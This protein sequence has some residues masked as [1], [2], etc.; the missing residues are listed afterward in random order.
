MK[1]NY[2]PV[3]SCSGS[4]NKEWF[5]YKD[6]QPVIFVA[7]PDEATKNPPSSAPNGT[8]YCEPD[9]KIINTEKTWRELV[10][11]Q[12]HPDLV[13]AYELYKND[14]YYKL[15]NE[16]DRYFYIISAGW[17]IIRASFKLPFYN[18]T[19][20]NQAKVPKYSRRTYNMKWNDF[21]HLLEDSNDFDDNS[22][23]I[24]FS[25]KD[26]I[27]PFCK[28]TRSIKKRK[29]IKYIAE[30]IIEKEGYEY[31]E[32]YKNGTNWQYEAAKDFLKS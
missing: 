18:I 10:K 23:I 8:L 3:L 5:N 17:G 22:V 21:N 12:N 31:E 28:M 15:F 29:I 27:E 24:L 13:P 16:Y 20:S 32:Y 2:I 9:G 6:K 26:Y 19:Y 14:I 1:K 7:S 4:K 30:N 25:G 11:E